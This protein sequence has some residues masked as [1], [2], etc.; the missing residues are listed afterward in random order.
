MTDAPQVYVIETTI[1]IDYQTIHRRYEAPT[2][3][4]VVRLAVRCGESFE[5]VAVFVEEKR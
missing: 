2:E 4:E 1:T 5:P 3:D